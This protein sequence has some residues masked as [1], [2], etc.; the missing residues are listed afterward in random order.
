MLARIDE[1]TSA[2]AATW[3]PAASL[4]EKASTRRIVLTALEAVAAP[5]PPS[6]FNRRSLARARQEL[7]QA[8][9]DAGQAEEARGRIDEALTER[10]ELVEE[11]P[12][13]ERLRADLLQSQISRGDCSP[14]PAGSRK[15]ARR[16]KKD[17]P[18]S[19]PTSRRTRIASLCA[20]P[21]RRRS[22]MSAI[23]MGKSGCS[24]RRFDS[25]GGR[26]RLRYLPQSHPGISLPC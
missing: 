15:R 17:S 11:E 1:L 7:A 23:N 9:L 22:G 24:P 6:R 18:P 19:K 14:R 21:L 13:D 5:L 12:N 26:S 8:L 4:E 16:G 20:S 2:D 25:I 10:K 3:N